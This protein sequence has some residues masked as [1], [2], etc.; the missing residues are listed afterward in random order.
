M[1]PNDEA[2]DTVQKRPKDNAINL[3]VK[4]VATNLID[5]VMDAI[6]SLDKAF[7]MDPSLRE[8]AKLDGDLLDLL[9]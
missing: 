2:S 5:K 7:D 8:L 1:K 9:D 6:M 4:A 3:Y